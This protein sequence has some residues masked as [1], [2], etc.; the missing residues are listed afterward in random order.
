MAPSD[1]EE[2][3]VLAAIAEY[4]RLGQDEFLR[5][6]NFGKSSKFRLLYNGRFYDSKAI[7]GVAHGFATN[8]FWTTERPFG[9]TGPGGA[10]TIL[11]SLG[12]FIDRGGLLFQ[13]TQLNVDQTHGKRAPYQYVVLL[14]AMARA[15][16]HAPRMVDFSD[17]RDE[18]RDLLAPFAIAKT[19][20]DPAMPWAALR[21]SPWW[22]LGTR[23]SSAVVTET[24]VKRLN[25]AGGLSEEMYW[26]TAENETF[27]SAA[28]DVIGE[29]IGTEP[30]Y[31]QL[32][33]KLDLPPKS[34]AAVTV[35]SPDGTDAI[36]AVEQVSE[37]RRRFSRRLSAAENKAIEEHAVRLTR[38]HFETELG[39]LT[40]D[41]GAT[42]SYD[43]H[44]TKGAE[45]LKVEVKGTTTNGV[46]VVLTRN[47]VDL[48]RMTHPNNAL[49]V[50]RN[51]VLNRAGDEPGD[52]PVATGGELV[53][54]MPWKVDET[55]LSAIAYEY[56]TG[57]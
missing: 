48:H 18:L 32:L 5:R 51:I 34:Q 33:Q 15:R 38:Q 9:G 12:F 43:V 4:D 41:V 3:S 8:D 11:E 31:V 36:A 54:V 27:A 44:A 26:R 17:A 56:R 28:V 29:L 37:P 42:K 53:L 14:W 52:E 16:A 47:E 30:A 24:D 25:I 22:E 10:V 39:Y 1:I 20:P 6:Y 45:V 57:F 55:A 7:A 46:S 19:A 23:A 49:A 13:L 40:E 21:K 2:S 35:G 50:V